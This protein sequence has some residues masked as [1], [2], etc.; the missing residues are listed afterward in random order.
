LTHDILSRDML[1]DDSAE[2]LISLS[3]KAW[4]QSKS[5]VF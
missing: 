2:T 4:V 5:N 3:K 1:V